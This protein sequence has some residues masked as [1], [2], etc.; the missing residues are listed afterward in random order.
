[1]SAIRYNGKNVKTPMQGREG[2]G[3]GEVGLGFAGLFIHLRIDLSHWIGDG[4]SDEV[5]L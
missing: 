3:M 1:M 2:E 4:R 5:G